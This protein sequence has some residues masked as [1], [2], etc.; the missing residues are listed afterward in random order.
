MIKN[1]DQC[2]SNNIAIAGTKKMIPVVD[3]KLTVL[4]SLTIYAVIKLA[5]QVTTPVVSHLKTLKGQ[6]PAA[7]KNRLTSSRKLFKTMRSRHA[8]RI[9]HCSNPDSSP[10]TSKMSS[11]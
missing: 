6:T 7:V 1:L 8:V 11:L 10:F 3:S 9:P 4:F 5:F 2:N